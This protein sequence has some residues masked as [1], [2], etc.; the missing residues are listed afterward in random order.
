[1]TWRSSLPWQQE[2]AMQSP[3][4]SKCLECT[5]HAHTTPAK[6]IPWLGCNGDGVYHQG[7]AHHGCVGDCERLAG[8]FVTEPS[9]VCREPGC[10]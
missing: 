6:V 1:M 9:G 7:L 8:F 4:V 5:S 10:H 2:C 3:V